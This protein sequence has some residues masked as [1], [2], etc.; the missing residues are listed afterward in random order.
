MNFQVISRFRDVHLP[1]KDIGHV[2]VEMLAGM[3]QYLFHPCR[4]KG[5]AQGRGFDK[6]GP[7]PDD[8]YNF[9][10]G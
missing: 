9:Q 7:G 6:L 1:E 4:A 5:A 8:G 10:H 3:D 2:V